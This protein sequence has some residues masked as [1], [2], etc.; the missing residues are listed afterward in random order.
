[1][2]K[3]QKNQSSEVLEKEVKEVKVPASEKFNKLLDKYKLTKNDK[4][5]EDNKT[6]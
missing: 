5:P 3:R 1:M 6:H 4:L 2:K